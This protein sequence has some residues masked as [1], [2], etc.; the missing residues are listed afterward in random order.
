MFNKLKQFK[1]I[2]DK[3]KVI[4]AALASEK[5]EGQAGWGKVKVEVDG[6]QHAVSVT[7]DPSAMEDKAKLEGMIKD[8]F[9]DAMQKIQKVMA[10]KL[11]DIGG[12]DLA[13]DMQDMMGNG[14]NS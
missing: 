12:L 9:N 3:A 14:E 5:A 10:T 7:I 8:A 11:K 6:N 1:D 13:K 4:Q 2:R